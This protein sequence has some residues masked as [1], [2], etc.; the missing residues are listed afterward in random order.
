MSYPTQCR[1][2][3]HK[4][5]PAE[6]L[7]AN[8][9]PTDDTAAAPVEKPVPALVARTRIVNTIE[10]LWQEQGEPPTLPLLFGQSDA[11]PSLFIKQLHKL[12]KM[13]TVVFQPDGRVFL[14]ALAAPSVHTEVR[15]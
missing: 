12:G 11:N 8:S 13:G 4:P 15:A 6:E 14:A 1:V 9:G 2:L 5:E 7:P 3:A 10:R